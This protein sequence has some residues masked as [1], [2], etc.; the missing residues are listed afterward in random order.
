[1]QMTAEL[2]HDKFK[3]ENINLPAFCSK[4][5]T[6]GAIWRHKCTTKFKELGVMNMLLYIDDEDIN[7]KSPHDIEKATNTM[8]NIWKTIEQTIHIG[9]E[10]QKSNF[11]TF[12]LP[13]RST[14]YKWEENGIFYK[15]TDEIKDITVDSDGFIKLKN[16]TYVGSTITSDLEDETDI[17]RCI[18][19]ANKAMGT[20]E[21]V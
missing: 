3:K 4:N 21:I 1:M 12:F 18:T 9:Q 10:S 14:L 17:K 13:A 20:F 8:Y 7:F 2:I 5:N 16:F 6:K 11:E 19:K 15:N